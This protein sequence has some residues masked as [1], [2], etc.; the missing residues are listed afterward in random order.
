MNFI[1]SKRR[2]IPRK[3]EEIR[4]DGKAWTIVQINQI[5]GGDFL[6]RVQDMAGNS[7]TVK[8]TKQG[9]KAA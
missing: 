5:P 9:R 4:L 1:S 8:L 2:N 3:G 7:M 6:A